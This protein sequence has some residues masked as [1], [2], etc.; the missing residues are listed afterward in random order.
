MGGTRLR[1]GKA[2]FRT[3][4]S[5]SFVSFFSSRK[6][7]DFRNQ[8]INGCFG[9]HEERSQSRAI[10]A[11]FSVFLLHLFLHAMVSGAVFVERVFPHEEPGLCAN[12]L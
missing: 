3:V 1:L 7:E 11:V 12:L 4:P 8:G 5:R 6:S 2:L 10:P 9:T